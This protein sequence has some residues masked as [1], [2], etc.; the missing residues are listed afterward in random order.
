[1]TASLGNRGLAG[2]AS[3]VCAFAVGCGR[4]DYQRD[5]PGFEPFDAAVPRDA[6]S[7]LLYDDA[8]RLIDTSVPVP[9]EQTLVGPAAAATVQGID[10]AP[11]NGPS[12]LGV[13]V[14]ISEGG[15]FVS[16]ASAASNLVAGDTNETV[17]VFVFEAATGTV[18]RIALSGA[19]PNGA[20]GPLGRGVAMGNGRELDNDAPT[21]PVLSADA[22]FVAFASLASNWVPADSNGHLDVFVFDRTART[23]E[24]VSVGAEGAQANAASWSPAISGDGEFVAFVSAATNLAES[25]FG[26]H[27][28]VFVRDRASGTTTIVSRRAD[29]VAFNGPSSHPAISADGAFVAFLTEATNVLANRLL[30]PVAK[31]VV[32]DASDGSFRIAS[33]ASG[34]FL[35]D[36][37]ASF[38]V[39]SGDGRYV[40]FLTSATNLGRDTNGLLDVYRHDLMTGDTFCISAARDG[41]AASAFRTR[42]AM[43]RD[44]RYVV[45]GSLSSQIVEN[46]YNAAGDVFLRDA[47]ADT[48]RV[49]SVTAAMRTAGGLSMPRGISPDG[50]AIVFTSQASNLVDGDTNDEADV[51]VI[52]TD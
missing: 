47:F 38:P 9:E 10:G 26:G 35:A 39:I 17:D 15:A 33:V 37:S 30:P 13:D 51:F 18:E 7:Q 29:G 49:V 14:D 45:F 40:S 28:D 24:R 52:S 48:T 34:G 50:T 32:R 21:G 42:P 8:G 11:S 19:E 12:G 44:G 4:V 27:T 1:M 23:A 5:T 25:D 2:V 3:L 46:D 36:R 31:V 22:S 6:G 16:F 43:S 41:T 20:S